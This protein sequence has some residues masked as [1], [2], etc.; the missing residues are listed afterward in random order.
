V[1]NVLDLKYNFN[2]GAGDNGNVIGITNNR[3]TTRSQSFTYDQLNRL[4]TAA[5]STYATSPAHCWGEQF[6]YDQWANLLSIGAISSA[7]TGCTQENLRVT[8]LTTNRLG[9]S[10]FFSFN[11]DT[12]G[13]LLKDPANTY[14]WNGESQLKSA[15][16]VTYTYDGD[17]NRV[18][19][20]NGK[21]YWYGM[22]SDPLWESDASG[23]ITFEY[24]F[25]GGKRVAR[26][27][28]AGNVNYYI[29]DHLGTSR[30]VTNGTGTIL[31]DSDFY[32]YGGERAY[33]SSSGNT[34]KFTGKERD[35]ESGLDDFGA[36]YYGSSLGRF[37]SVDPVIITPE[38]K[39]DPQ[40][41]NRY[42]YVRNN[43]LRFIDP[44]GEILQL[45]GDLAAD[46]A[47]ICDIVG[48]D[49]CS[50]I[51]I[52]EKNN[53]VSFDTS[54]LDLSANEGAT[55]I[56]QLVTS[57]D[58]YGFA[59]SDTANTAG[60]PVKLT[61]DPISNLDNQPDDR[62]GKGKTATDMPPKGVAD[63]VTINP[64]TAHF[65][66][67]QG[68]SVFISSLAFHELAEAYGKIDGGKAYGDFQNINVVNGTTLQ[69]GPPQQGAHNQ[70]VQREFKLREQRPNLQNSGR[71]GDQLIRDPH[72]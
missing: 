70:A 4:A 11:Y 39:L 14:T 50:R 72:N 2:L 30:L 66:D 68:R 44:T 65:K 12:A 8:V 38:R 24:I 13:N 58:T 17:G 52:D 7:Y 67:S 53:T 1:G 16:G 69:I 26:R 61:N 6:G 64:N 32:P 45:S 29:A 49:N 51:T 46:K 54:G 62:Y 23:N 5:A 34:Y 43:P 37:M 71:A 27:D 31:D 22:S 42:A 3:D 20:S 48:S 18:Q 57:S 55:L 36:R 9:R 35:S 33:S 25:F 19:K 10:G 56:N 40:Q 47:A 41:L 15:A 59:L 63:Q 28:S 21:L 60:G